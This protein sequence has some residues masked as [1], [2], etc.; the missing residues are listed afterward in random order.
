M[1]GQTDFLFVTGKG[2]AFDPPTVGPGLA[3][4][5]DGTSNTMVMVEIK[6]S[7]INWAE[8]RDLDISQPMSLP[9][10]NHPNVNMAVFFDGHTYAIVKST[11]AADHPRFGDLR[12]RR[13][14]R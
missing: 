13:T 1:P 5:T 10:G 12:R 9:P 3:K 4:L 8:P 14:N 6:N 7:G 2:T 11:A